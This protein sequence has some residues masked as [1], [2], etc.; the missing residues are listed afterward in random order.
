M[1]EHLSIKARNL[2]VCVCVCLCMCASNI[3]ADQDQTD[4]RFSTWLLH[5][6]RVCNGRLVWNTMILLLNDFINDLPIPLAL[7]TIATIVTCAPEPITAHH[8]HV[9][10]RANHCRARNKWIY[11]C[12]CAS[13]TVILPAVRSHSM[14]L[15]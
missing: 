13:W 3:S 9:H 4:L 12:S 1:Y 8:S 6:L 14:D 10:T 7:S 11:T 5:G 15:N 2:S